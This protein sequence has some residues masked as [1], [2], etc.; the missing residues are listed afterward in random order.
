MS[1]LPHNRALLEAL[2]SLLSWNPCP[3]SRLLT[4]GSKESDLWISTSRDA[5]GGA[6]ASVLFRSVTAR[7]DD[8]HSEKAV[9]R[10][11]SEGELTM[12]GK[13]NMEQ[14][15]RPG[16]KSGV[17]TEFTV[18]VNVKPGHE[19]AVREAIE[20]AAH[21]PHSAEAVQQIGTLHEA[22]YVL[23]DN[24]RRLMFCSSF[25]GT[26]DKYIDDFATTY[27]ANVFDAVFSH[28]EGFPGIKDP[29]VKD[30]FMTNAREAVQF[31]SAYPDASVKQIWK[32]LAV[33]KAFEQV[34][35]NP[36]AEQALQAPAL[37]PLLEQA[38]T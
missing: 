25:D 16:L 31:I 38:A 7:M 37:K 35:D 21:G 6:P 20:H 24:D 10:P 5:P 14:P 36:A 8:E 19:Q 27:I 18:Y 23:F 29:N 9:A 3:R 4:N 1:E 12:K 2:C 32:A 26:W 30:W 28:C 13:N 17:M 33:E 22:R 15:K 34:L 11:P